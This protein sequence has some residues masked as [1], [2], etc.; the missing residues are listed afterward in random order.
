[1]KS[2]LIASVI[3]LTATGALAGDLGGEISM[4]FSKNANDKIVAE[5]GVDLIITGNSGLAGSVGLTV[6]GND[7]VKLDSYSVGTTLGANASVSIGKQGDLLSAFEGQTEK[8]GGQTLANPD[9]EYVSVKAEAFGVQAL[10]GFNDI[11]SDMSD[12]KNVQLGYNFSLS[13]VG[14]GVAV[15]WDEASNDITAALGANVDVKGITVGGTLTYTDA[16]IGY[17]VSAGYGAVRGFV[18]GDDTDAVQN[19]GGGIYKDFSTGMGLYAE[20]GYN[21]DSKDLTPAAGVSFKF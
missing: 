3:T 17:E 7:T 2:A 9:D 14:A 1:M 4:D 10:V 8:V 16:A 15:N 12:I 11:A 18:N 5:T 13:N 21:L 19:V 20:A 6:D